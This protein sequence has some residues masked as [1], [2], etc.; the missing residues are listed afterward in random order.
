MV[1]I[2]TIEKN[3]VDNFAKTLM[4]KKEDLIYI[5]SLLYDNLEY[6]YLCIHK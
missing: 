5:I 1:K 4:N 3:Y 6:F 2:I